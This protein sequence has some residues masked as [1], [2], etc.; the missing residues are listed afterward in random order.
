[1]N[2]KKIILVCGPTGVG[3]TGFAI[4]L[5]TRVGAEIIGA[6]SMQI[7]RYMDVGT[8]KPDAREQSAVRHYL[9]DVVDPDQDFDA[10]CFARMADLAIEE[11][12]KKGRAAVVAGGTGFYFKALVHGLFRGT[13]A[14]PRV[15]AALEQE[16]AKGVDLHARLLRVDPSAA[17][18]IH[19][20]DLFR[21]IRALEVATTHNATISS[22][23]EAHGFE[24]ERYRALKFGLY[25]DREKL[26]QR[27]EKRVD[28]ML[29]QGLIQEVEGLLNRGYTSDLKSM[30]SIG[31]RHVCLYLK[32]EIGFNE[33]VGL[34]KRDTRRYAKRQLTWF[35]REKEMIW[36]MPQE[37]ERAF[38][39]ASDFLVDRD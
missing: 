14:D 28:M 27:I 18:K 35:R 36:L 17:A 10:A 19:P 20:N 23:Q 9:V 13:K 30:Q 3:K 38:S 7:Y 1:M 32:G 26:Y 33:M 15:L 8:A 11:L 12:H 31:Y 24:G 34:L 22:L 39:L 5:A 2:K 37:I 29:D 21:V 4:D 16:A 25:M 6:D